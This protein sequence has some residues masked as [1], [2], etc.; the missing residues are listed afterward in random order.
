MIFFDYL[1]K[2]Y[3]KL[4]VRLVKRSLVS[5]SLDLKLMQK[6]SGRRF[7]SLKQ[8]AQVR[9]ILSPLEKRLF[10]L[11]FFLFLTGVA[12]L[13]VIWLNHY[14][15]Q[16]PTVGGIY[17]EAVVGAPQSVNPI[18]ASLNDVDM[19]I[20]KLVY[21][22][23]M[24][25]DGQGRLL[26]DLAA[27]YTVSPD[28][29]IYTFQLRKDVVWH[30]GEKFTAKDVV[31]TFD[32]L[33]NPAVNSP[34]G[35][36][37][38]GVKVEAKEEYVVEFTLPTSF[39]S[40]LS[41][42]TTGILPEHVWTDIQP[43]QMRFAGINLKPTGTGPFKFKKFVKDDSGR[44]YRYEL[45]R[46]DKFYRVGPYLEQ[47]VFQFYSDYEGDNG[48][49]EALRETKVD[50][51][52]YV[53]YNLKDKVER[54]HLDLHILQLPQYTALFFNADHQSLLKDKNLKISLAYAIDKDRIL[55]E[56][57]K[58]NGQLIYGPILP[59]F[60]G[61]DPNI[62]KTPYSYEEANRLLDAK[63]TRVS[64]EEYYNQLK[65]ELLKQWDIDH[66]SSTT[67][68]VALTT[69]TTEV[70]SEREEAIKQIDEKLQSEL[71]AAQ[72]F[73]RKNK[74]G[75]ILELNITTVDTDQY[76]RVAQIIAGF[77]QEIG[78][79]TNIQLVSTK[80][81]LREVIKPRSYDILLYGE[82]VGSD[83]DPYPF[84]HSSQIDYPGLNLSR[85]VNRSA[86]E[87]MEKARATNDS[88]QLQTLY[89]SFQDIVV[90]EYP[91]IFL[92]MPTYTYATND[93]IHGIQVVNINQPADRFAGVE[94]WYMNTTGQWK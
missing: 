84:W 36:G 88:Q 28:K 34:L 59:G 49:I 91:A 22:G 70:I 53:P 42:L 31:F 69:S 40:F 50:G 25:F 32:S 63:W 89:K 75:Q 86:D 46:F 33:Q 87:L 41:A 16:A 79:K 38:N 47:F 3:F 17:V 37:F 51:L 21:S 57:L 66:P 83:P 65:N 26:P 43:E 2:L 35:V 24:R 78:V 13:L 82:I 39:N 6:A 8:L 9:R 27:N 72:T 5:T 71:Q 92:Y 61:F 14:R 62:T 80:D 64:A 23:L 56:I 73:Y 29:K 54:K 12:W 77:W 45:D 90:V 81:I 7:P 10:I 76:T 55:R 93:T 67:S 4:K 11:S 60:P 15:I 1:K 18:F 68:T 30:D 52:S 48:A 20:S 58:N 44:I 94:T 85:F 74:E 19:D